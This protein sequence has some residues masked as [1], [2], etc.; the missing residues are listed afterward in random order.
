VSRVE[1]V[2]L[3]EFSFSVPNIGLETAAAGVGNM[4]YVQGSTFT[5]KRWA[6]RIY[7]SDGAMGGYV[8]NWVG[9]PAAF[10]Q[11][12]ML[13]PLLVGRDPA[14]REA[15]YNDLKWELRAY[16]HMG[17][18]PLDIALWDLVGRQHNVSIKTLLGGF[19]DKLP[20]YA[21]T[22]GGQLG[23][24]GLNSSAAYA[25]YAEHCQRQGFHGFKIHGWK[26]GDVAQEAENLRGIR[27]RV[28][29][30]FAL[31]IDPACML[32]TWNDALALG[33]VADEVGCLWYEDPYLD[34][35]VSAPGHQRLREK[36]RTPL[37]VSEH[38][39]GLEQK[40][41]FV[42]AGG[43]D[44]VHADPEYDMGITGVMKLAHFCEG[45]GL[46]LQLHAVGPAHRLCLSA[47]R[48]SLM[49]EMALIGPDM[50]NMVA[51]VYRCGYSD[52]EADLPADGLVPVPDG[53]GLGVDYDWEYVDE[54]AINHLTFS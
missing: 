4:A 34:G 45:M 10:G 54:H 12:T 41:A 15:I 39:R 38:V 14:E 11:A 37:L 29:D 33:R 47:I 8:T 9:T 40:A 5:A 19:R 23:P 49:Y 46:D 44:M 16:D 50:P 35:A 52:L 3:T 31:M 48:N 24:G 1:S 36:L 17:H 7:D 27:A 30:D 22:Y 26:Q 20:T 18:G 42:L 25:D 6:V 28:G 43:A 13:A 2:A 53:P 21:S 32:K 51:P